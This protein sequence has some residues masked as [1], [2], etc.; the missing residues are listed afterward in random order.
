MLTLIL[1]RPAFAAELPPPGL[2]EY[3]GAM[4]DIGGDLVDPLALEA[5]LED[6]IVEDADSAAA[7]VPA[8]DAPVTDIEVDAI[9]D[10]DPV[11]KEEDQ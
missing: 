2:L 6:A 5:V 3:L 9:Q 7:N 8:G 4:V 10:R 1:A 11:S